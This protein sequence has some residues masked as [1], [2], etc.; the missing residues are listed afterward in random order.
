MAKKNRLT[1][2][3]MSDSGEGEDSL[4]RCNTEFDRVRGVIFRK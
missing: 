3:S 1:E 4:H 2:C